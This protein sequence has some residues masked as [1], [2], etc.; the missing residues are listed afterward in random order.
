MSHLDFDFAGRMRALGFRVT[1]QRQLILD[2]LCHS[3]GHVTPE[4]LY[5]RVHAEFPAINRATVYRTLN[6]LCDLRLVVALRWQGQTYYEIAGDP[7]HHHLV[8]RACG[9]MQELDNAVLEGLAAKVADQHGFVLDRDHVALA[10]LC[11]D[12]AGGRRRRA[13]KPQ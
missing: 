13:R 6:F 9:R 12:C 10:G 11:S 1:P 7:G 2:A 4:A 8:C 3:G 5:E